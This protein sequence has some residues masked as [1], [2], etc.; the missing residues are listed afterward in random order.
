MIHFAKKIDKVKIYKQFVDSESVAGRK[1]FQ[2]TT[3]S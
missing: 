3:I 1:L 2:L